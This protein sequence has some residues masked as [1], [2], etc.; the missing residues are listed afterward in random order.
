MLNER[1]I[2]DRIYKLKQEIKVLNSVINSNNSELKPFGRP[3][4]SWKY[5]LEQIDFL[6]DCKKKGLEQK[7]IIKQ[8][9]IKFGTKF[10]ENTRALY[11]FMSRC[12]IISPTYSP[13]RFT[14]EED[15]YIMDNVNLLSKQEIANK[16]DRTRRKR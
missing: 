1:Q 11:N 12:K 9:N 3:K 14:E 10:N 16:L 2:K 5:S 7:E 13:R 15:K 8:F 6:K 4:G